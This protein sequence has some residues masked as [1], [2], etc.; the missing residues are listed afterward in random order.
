MLEDS[1]EVEVQRL[2]ETSSRIVPDRFRVLGTGLMLWARS[3]R[4]RSRQQVHKLQ[5]CLHLLVNSL[6]DDAAFEEMVLVKM[7][8]NMEIDK[9]ERY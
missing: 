5:E 1:C 2:W 8:L 4:R 7:Q 3:I 6:S 9:F